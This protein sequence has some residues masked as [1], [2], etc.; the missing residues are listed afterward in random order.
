MLQNR[1]HPS[2]S[3]HVRQ[4][5]APASTPH[6]G[7]HVEVERPPQHLGES[8]LAASSAS[9]APFWPLPLSPLSPPPYLL[10]GAISFDDDQLAPRTAVDHR[11][12][13]MPRAELTRRHVVPSEVGASVL[14]HFHWAKRPAPVAELIGDWA[15]SC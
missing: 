12:S 13:K 6:A 10:G 5:P 1:A 7:E 2:C 8:P 3:L 15:R 14:S 4:H 9:S 11:V